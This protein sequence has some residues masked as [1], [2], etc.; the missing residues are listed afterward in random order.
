MAPI[1]RWLRLMPGNPIR[2]MVIGLL[3][4]YA[5]DAIVTVGLALAGAPWITWA[6]GAIFLATAV[7]VLP[8]VAI[9]GR[10]YGTS[11]AQLL[12]GGHWARWAVDTGEGA[13]F[14]ANE[15]RR[16]RR[17][18]RNLVLFGM[19]AGPVF[20]LLFGLLAGSMT[21]FGLVV[22]LMVGVGILAAANV[23]AI[24]WWRHKR[25]AE[26]GGEVLIG[27]MGVFSQGTFTPLAGFNLGLG[28]V[29]IEE[30]DPPV[31]RFDAVTRTYSEG[32]I[33]TRTTRTEPVRVPIPR[34][35]ESEAAALVARFRGEAT[36][37]T[38]SR[39]GTQGA[40]RFSSV[41]EPTGR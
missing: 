17:E 9:F 12:D 2:P 21:A 18:A 29:E 33:P 23:L 13:R 40:P 1:I 37:P 24:G 8:I 31:I 4:F 32:V 3:G 5:L 25:R 26:R 35:R 34:G 20:G 19:G 27:P 39:L 16:A 36:P 10:I 7:V 30:G 14:A 28:A 11:L 22:A 41:G 6:V 38:P 15:W